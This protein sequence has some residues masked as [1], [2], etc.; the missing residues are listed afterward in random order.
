MHS[1]VIGFLYLVSLYQHKIHL[2]LHLHG[3]ICY[4]FSFCKISMQ[5]LVSFFWF[6][7]LACSLQQAITALKKGAQLLKYGRRGKPKFCPFRVANVRLKL[8]QNVHMLFIN[9]FLF[10]VKL[11]TIRIM[12][13]FFHPYVWKFL[14]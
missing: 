14:E 8:Y 9:Y 4:L 11:S 6:R 12:D 5:T 3:T 7:F 10:D 2:M 13:M 1:F